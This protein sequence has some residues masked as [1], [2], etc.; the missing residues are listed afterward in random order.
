MD[1]FYFI[2]RS[3]VIFYALFL[4]S[5]ASFA[6]AAFISGT[7][8]TD[9]SKLVALQDLEWMSLEH[10]ADLTRS[11]IE[12]GFTDSYGVTWSAG[13]W[14]YAT[15]GET[16]TL[17]GSLWGG[18]WSGW[19]SS[20]ADGATWFLNH[21]WGIAFDYYQ[22]GLRIDGSINNES[23][24]EFNYSFFF[25]GNP[26]ECSTHTGAFCIGGVMYFMN[27]P[28]DYLAALATPPY[29]TMVSRLANSGP[30]GYLAED[31]GL[32]AS[33]HSDNASSQNTNVQPEVGHLLVRQMSRSEAQSV[34]TPPSIALMWFGLIALVI[35]HRKQR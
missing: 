25:F 12:D 21:F 10:S 7:H 22:D 23:F 8:Y 13:E 4:V 31:F 14:R 34:P 35:Q 15:R 1:S 16:E 32:N 19:A 6:Q 24:T 29:P 17:L 27:S 11:D 33:I 28:S 2:F 30:A 5:W 20:N 26:Y 18:V 9:G 3:R